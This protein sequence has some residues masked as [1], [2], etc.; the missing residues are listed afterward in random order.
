MASIESLWRWSVADKFMDWS[1]PENVT[2][3]GPAIQDPGPWAQLRE[4]LRRRIARLRE[5]RK[6]RS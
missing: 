2:I 1:K 5:R 3:K 4:D 6:Q